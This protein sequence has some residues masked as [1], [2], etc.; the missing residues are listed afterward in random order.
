MASIDLLRSGQPL[1]TQ[2]NSTTTSAGASS[3]AQTKAAHGS[4]ANTSDSISL[5]SQARSV[6]Q[7]HQHLAA[8]P[9]FDDV[10][11]NQ[12]KEAIANGSY[13]IDADKLAAN[14]LKFENELKDI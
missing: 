8:E 14:M 12:I 5:S 9:S 13:T 10:K 4:D 7:I 6:G 1:A 2:R 3:S 11:V